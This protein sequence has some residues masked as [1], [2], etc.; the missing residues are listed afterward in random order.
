MAEPGGPAAIE[1]SGLLAGRRDV[2]DLNIEAV[3]APWAGGATAAEWH[4]Q[5][6]WL[7]LRRAPTAVTRDQRRSRAPPLRR[8][9]LGALRSEGQSRIEMV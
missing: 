3:H 2:V 1:T 5:P 9:D 6:R 7:V 4:R 8:A